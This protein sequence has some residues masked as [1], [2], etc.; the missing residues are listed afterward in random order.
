MPSDP[1]APNEAAPAVDDELVEE[2]LEAPAA[3]VPVGVVLAVAPS[4]FAGSESLLVVL[5]GT[6]VLLL[7]TGKGPRA[8]VLEEPV[9]EE[10]VLEE[11]AT[12]ATSAQSL[13]VAGRT[14]PGGG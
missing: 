4:E 8:V 2:D 9:L 1:T 12:G 5:A 14:W 6:V 10:P 11:P 13:A 3:G 7:G